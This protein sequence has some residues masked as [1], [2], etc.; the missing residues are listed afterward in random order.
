MT[1]ERHTNGRTTPTD[2]ARSV[3]DPVGPVTITV[4]GPDRAAPVDQWAEVDLSLSMGGGVKHY[5]CSGGRVAFCGLDLR[6][7][8]VCPA[9]M[10]CGCM[11]CP[12]CDR[13]HRRT[14]PACPLTG[15]PC[16]CV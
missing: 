12:D 13:V 5:V 4:A 7:A 2:D 15:G 8:H 14:L 1:A 11:V 3:V 16:D 10:S 9:D 6:G